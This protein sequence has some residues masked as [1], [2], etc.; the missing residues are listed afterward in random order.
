M[1]SLV[2]TTALSVLMFNTNIEA[3]SFKP[4][5]AREALAA[6]LIEVLP[7]ENDDTST[8]MPPQT[9]YKSFILLLPTRNAEVDG[10]VEINFLKKFETVLEAKSKANKVSVEFPTTSIHTENR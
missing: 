6:K 4:K 3:Q 1:K 2:L 9:D 10:D 5:S 8:I 7:T